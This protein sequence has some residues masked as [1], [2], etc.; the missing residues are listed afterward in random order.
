MLVAAAIVALTSDHRAPRPAISVILPRARPPPRSA[1]TAAN[2]V[3]IT[4]SR[5]CRA[6]ERTNSA[7]L[8]SF[9]ATA[10]GGAGRGGE[11]GGG[12]GGGGRRRGW[13]GN[14]NDLQLS[15]ESSGLCNHGKS[16]QTQGRR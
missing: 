12:G 9:A 8:V 2:V 6:S 11:R 15:F 7:P 5:R 10:G 1:S 3:G 4:S 13:E 14:W 16:A